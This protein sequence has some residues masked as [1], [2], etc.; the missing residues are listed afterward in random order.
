MHRRH[1][2]EASLRCI[3]AMH[4]DD[5]SMRCIDAQGIRRGP[6]KCCNQN[7]RA[8]LLQ[9][10]TKTE[11]EDLKTRALAPLFSGKLKNSTDV[12]RSPWGARSPAGPPGSLAL[13]LS[14]NPIV[15]ALFGAQ[16]KQLADNFTIVISEAAQGYFEALKCQATMRNMAV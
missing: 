12:H 9:P 15:H 14:Q 4:R 8:K 13:Q 6:K 1:R 11:M 7:E 3:D 5:A 16:D 10:S 2:S